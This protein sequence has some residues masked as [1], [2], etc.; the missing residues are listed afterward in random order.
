MNPTLPLDP[1]MPKS[2]APS[3]HLAL[4]QSW[5]NTG[6]DIV[7][8]QCHEPLLRLDLRRLRIEP[9]LRDWVIVSCYS[10]T[11]GAPTPSNRRAQARGGSGAWYA[12]E[13]TEL[14]PHVARGLNINWDEAIRYAGLNAEF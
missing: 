2:R 13:L 7:R 5:S 9:Q 8:A 14:L 12:M 6:P 10:P 1:T 3:S 11:N 4:R